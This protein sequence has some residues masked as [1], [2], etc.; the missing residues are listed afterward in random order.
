MYF[1]ANFITNIQKNLLT[2][3]TQNK[4][5]TPAD[6]KIISQGLTRKYSIPVLEYFDKERV[7]IRVGDTR[8]L[9]NTSLLNTHE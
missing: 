3:F 6:F 2:F 9:R 7:T 1:N 5:M 4:A 8:Q